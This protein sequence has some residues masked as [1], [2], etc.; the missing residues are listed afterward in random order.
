MADW[1]TAAP[2]A[3]GNKTFSHLGYAPF[4]YAPPIPTPEVT[5][6]LT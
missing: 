6:A 4:D 5:L 1:D 3:E 2:Q